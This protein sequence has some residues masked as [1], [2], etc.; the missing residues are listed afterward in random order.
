MYKF[1]LPAIPLALLFCLSLFFASCR[2]SESVDFSFYHWKAKAKYSQT[3]EKA[4][5]Q[6]D[7]STIYMHYFD[8]QLEKGEG[9][10]EL[11]PVYVL[12]E[13][14]KEY[15]NY[16]IVPVVFI[17]NEAMKW[18]MDIENLSSRIH[19]LIDEISQLQFNKKIAKIQLDCDWNTSSRD[20]YFELIELL[21]KHYDVS[22][23]I[24]LHQIK[25]KD[26]TGVPPVENGAL[27]LYNV[28]KLD[29]EQQNSILQSDIV[30]SYIGEN[31]AYP[32]DLKLALPVFSQT[33]II[34]K[35][36]DIRLVKGVDRPSIKKDTEHFHQTDD[37][38]FEVVKDTLYQGFYLSEGYKLKLEEISE[39][40]I[41]S[42]AAI[43]KNS[44]LNTSG[45][46][47]YHLDE[48]TLTNI[49][50][51]NLLEQL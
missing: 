1:S 47:F 2:K 24:R 17:T 12:N 41:I 27:M 9:D 26:K 29:N 18:E 7:V 45:I 11:F 5:Q 8:V 50:I 33:V 6:A 23:T 15:A 13:V 37:N 22:V 36:N 48:Q 21:K 25:Y 19:T 38:L 44:K 35:K 39:S 30:S 46:I 49:N 34:N 3:I 4:L 20:N 43:I 16:D 10:G 31:T 28:G 51:T 40:E 32:I 14:D 42:S